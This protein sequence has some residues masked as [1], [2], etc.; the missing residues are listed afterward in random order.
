M[1]FSKLTHSSTNWWD[2]MPS[3]LQDLRKQAP[4]ICIKVSRMRAENDR[5]VIPRS[6]HGRCKSNQI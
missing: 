6:G 5:F 4:L 2:R 1:L 3:S